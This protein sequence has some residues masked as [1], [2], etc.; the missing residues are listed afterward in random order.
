MPT[1]ARGRG[2]HQAWFLLLATM[3]R[4]VLLLL[5]CVQA[6][7]AS[8]LRSLIADTKLLDEALLPRL[9]RAT[10]PTK[11]EVLDAMEDAAC[12][13]YTMLGR[14]KLEARPLEELIKFAADA[15]HLQ[16]F[17]TPEPE[18]VVEEEPKC[19]GK[20]EDEWK[21]WAEA[22]GS[23][24]RPHIVSADGRLHFVPE[25]SVNAGLKYAR[26]LFE[27]VPFDTSAGKSLAFDFEAVCMGAR[28]A[29]LLDQDD[30]FT[31]T[32]FDKNSCKDTDI[33]NG[34]TYTSDLDAMG[35]QTGAKSPFAFEF[36]NLKLIA[37]FP[38]TI[39]AAKMWVTGFNCLSQT[40]DALGADV[41]SAPIP[42]LLG[43][44]NN[45][46]SD[47]NGIAGETTSDHARMALAILYSTKWL[48]RASYVALGRADGRWMEKIN[49]TWG[50]GKSPPPQPKSSFAAGFLSWWC[51]EKK[52]IADEESGHFGANWNAAVQ[53]T[54]A[55]ITDKRKRF[56]TAMGHK[57]RFRPNPYFMKPFKPSFE[58]SNDDPPKVGWE[59]LMVCSTADGAKKHVSRIVAAGGEAAPSDR[60]N[61]A[62]SL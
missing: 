62:N 10:A 28:L 26:S 58:V 55:K 17:A 13:L 45:L 14:D 31:T 50:K 52:G 42:A 48:T 61:D 4:F 51:D 59:S 12:R 5:P 34:K 37:T 15:C 40:F 38:G 54:S 36:A 49:P 35:E 56:R 57:W 24:D 44:I 9:E 20:T 43:T 3:L 21:E 46:I 33:L 1:R 27:A 2:V 60:P 53:S 47:G 22:L 6:L 41:T 7:P 25:G 18:V 16:Q 32:K 19:S 29:A 30:G 8:D 39:Y 23:K 11:E